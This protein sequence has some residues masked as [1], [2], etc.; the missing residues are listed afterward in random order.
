[1]SSSEKQ[2]VA[3]ISMGA[4]A[5]LAGAKFLAALFT[6]SLGILSEAIHSLID[7]G[8]T[9]VTYFAIRVS[10][11]PADDEHHY[12]HA[13]IESVAAL[14]ETGLLFLTTGW[15]CWEAIRRLL[16]EDIHEV[17]VTWWAVAIIAGS[18]IIDFN[19]ARA[20]KKVADKTSSEALE[21]D[22]LH[23]S[24]DMWSSIVVL[25]G[26][27]AVWAG[28]PAADSI[29][30]L[31]VSAFI[32]H[33]A[34]ELGAR[35]VNTLMDT[36]PAGATEIVRGLVNDVHGVLAL[37]SI[38]LRPAGATMFT[39]IVVEVARTMPIDDIV[40][41]KDAIT[42][43]VQER[44]PN[45]DITV[46][47]N[48]VPL[49]S[50]TVFQKVMLIASRRNLAIHHLNAQQIGGRLAISFDLEVD[51]SMPLGE[52]HER[53]TEL[54]DAIRTELGSD[55]E[56]ESHIEPQPERLLQGHDAPKG[57]TAEVSAALL[58]LAA[59]HPRLTDIHQVRLRRNEEGLF[60]HY[61]CRCSPTET[62]ENIHD[63][64]DRVEAGLKDRFPDIRRVIAHA[65]PLDAEQHA[66]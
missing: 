56:V 11:R 20:L 50:E 48:P 45:A 1:M 52:A 25:V 26:L 17:E 36:A 58:T 61:H 6:G 23:F 46:T 54:E 7:F 51:G 21:A 5:L 53:A 16:G 64:I 12:G 39:S 10:D 44:F 4:S 42:A 49:D 18:I 60:L 43:A 35:T 66:L 8:A 30:A 37:K 33:A 62:V 65:E 22:A 32:A 15:I 19:R 14:V 28:I 57:L 59:A 3:L 38:R 13:K 2:S 27:G 47:A 24:S 41:T 63:D 29:A 55:A 31:I 40:R 9:I 34:W